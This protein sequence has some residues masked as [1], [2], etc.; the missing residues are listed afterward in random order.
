MGKPKNFQKIL[1]KILT[2]F[3][4]CGIKYLMSVNILYG[5]KSQ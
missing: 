3:V 4:E 2:K 1:K 5:D